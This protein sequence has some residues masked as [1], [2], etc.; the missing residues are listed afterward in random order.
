MNEITLLKLAGAAHVTSVMIWIGGVAFVTLILIPS[1]Q[2]IS[3]EKLKFELFERL[4]HRFSFVAKI[5]VLLAGTSGTYRL[6][7]MNAWNRLKSTQFWWL[8]LMIAIW[9]VFALVLFVQ[10]Q[11]NPP[12]NLLNL[13]MD[14]LPFTVFQF[15]CSIF[16][17]R[18]SPR[19]LFLKCL[20]F[21]I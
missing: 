18:W 3:D 20:C 6:S 2:K 4:E 21:S 14:A 8:H 12:S 11:I 15:T 1:L 17:N 13:K 5:M 10:A 19:V 7:Y 9:L 16:W